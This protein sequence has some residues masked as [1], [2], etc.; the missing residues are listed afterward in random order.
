MRDEQIRYR[1][2]NVAS[3]E[4]LRNEHKMFRQDAALEAYQ[5]S[6][7]VL[8]KEVKIIGKLSFEERCD[9]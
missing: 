1:R 4:M 7:L 5:K 8:D 9:Y 3:I 6:A 2:H